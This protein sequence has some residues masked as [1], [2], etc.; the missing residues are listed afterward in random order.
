MQIYLLKEQESEVW[1][2]IGRITLFL[3]VLAKWLLILTQ[4]GTDIHRTVNVRLRIQGF[5]DCVQFHHIHDV[6]LVGTKF[7]G[8]PLWHVLLH[9]SFVLLY[10]FTALCVPSPGWEGEEKLNLIMNPLVWFSFLKERG[11]RVWKGS[12]RSTTAESSTPRLLVS[13]SLERFSRKF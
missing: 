3:V 1:A 6:N 13:V 10:L 5:V 11:S 7:S 12:I 9:Y 4:T 2:H 8:L